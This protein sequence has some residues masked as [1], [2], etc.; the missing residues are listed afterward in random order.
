MKKSN[1]QAVSDFRRNRKSNLIKVCGNKCCICGYDKSVSALEFH[2]II[3]ENK[4]YGIASNGTC[5]NIQKDLNEVKKCILVCANCHREI[6][7]NAYTQEELFNKQYFDE[8]FANELISLKKDQTYFCSECGTEITRYSD[9][10]LCNI[11]YNKTRR[12]CQ[13]PSREEL[14]EL[15]Q[16][17][18]FVQIGKMYGVSD[19]AVRKWCKQYKLP[20]KKQDIVSITDWDNV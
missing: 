20:S 15:I 3:P 5:H 11:C 2:H 17:T 7:E 14:K 16:N 10:G 19:N 4:E 1:S 6:H 12:K 8:N 13:H 18:S 9:T